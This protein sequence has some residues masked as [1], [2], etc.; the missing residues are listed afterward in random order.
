[1]PHQKLTSGTEYYHFFHTGQWFYNWS[2]SFITVSFVQGF[3]SA[4][5]THDALRKAY[6]HIIFYDGT[7]L[8]NLPPYALKKLTSMTI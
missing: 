2:L 7:V 3:S 6:G 8:S 5:A 4:A 1:M